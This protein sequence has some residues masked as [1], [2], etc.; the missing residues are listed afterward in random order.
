MAKIDNVDP[1][2][3]PEAGS[4]SIGSVTSAD[5]LVYLGAEENGYL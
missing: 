2:T 4:E 5:A 3:A 1:L